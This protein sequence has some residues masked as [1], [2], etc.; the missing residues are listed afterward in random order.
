MDINS[1]A[2]YIKGLAEGLGINCDSKEGKVIS[3]L[4]EL[5]ENMADKISELEAECC[6]LREYVEEIDSDL[7]ALE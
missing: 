3:A 7:G 5:C 6:E 4:I 2:A 1:N